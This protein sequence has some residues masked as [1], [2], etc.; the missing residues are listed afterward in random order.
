LAEHDMVFPELRAH[1]EAIGYVCIHWA[2]LEHHIDA[3]LAMLTPLESGAVHT[4]VT[5]GI[6]FRS[7]LAILK[8]LAHIRQL[9]ADWFEAVK[10]TVD[11]IDNELRA[12]RNRVVHD[13][14]LTKAFPDT[15]GRM[16]KSTKLARPSKSETYKLE[17]NPV[18]PVAAAEIEMLAVD[19]VK[20][21]TILSSL[22][23]QYLAAKNEHARPPGRE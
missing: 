2:H 5:T 14:W 15:P 1:A 11:L 16:T 19:I 4:V 9:N 17:T 7:K 23:G 21:A 6:P 12:A 20:A 10:T 3:C 8:S 22:C 18:A 13:L